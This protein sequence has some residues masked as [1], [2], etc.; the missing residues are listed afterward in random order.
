[1]LGQIRQGDVLLVPVDEKPPTDTLIKRKVV[2]AEGEMTGHAHTLAAEAGIIAWRDMVWVLG[3]EPGVLFH[4]EHDPAPA[5]VVTPGQAY[6]VVI[7]R[8]YSLD[9]MWRQ[10]VD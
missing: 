10:V 3:N 5:P 7:Q 4:E 2:L 8:E 6:R 9:G 1:M